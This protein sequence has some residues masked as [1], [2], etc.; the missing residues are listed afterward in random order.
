MREGTLIIGDPTFCSVNGV[1]ID[2][3]NVG[4]ICGIDLTCGCP[5]DIDTTGCL[6]AF[7]AFFTPRFLTGFLR[8]GPAQHLQ[9]I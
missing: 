8:H 2:D 7:F 4:A 6:T 9:L 1:L 3:W 5:N